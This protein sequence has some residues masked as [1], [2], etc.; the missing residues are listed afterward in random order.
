MFNS[1]TNPFSIENIIKKS[2]ERDLSNDSGYSALSESGSEDGNTRDNSVS[3]IFI[4]YYFYLFIFSYLQILEQVRF[5]QV[6]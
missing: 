5:D 6:P 3:L 1:E 4:N 2:G